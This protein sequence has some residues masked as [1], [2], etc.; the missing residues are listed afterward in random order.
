MTQDP[1]PEQ[2]YQ[3]QDPAEQHQAPP[4]PPPGGQPPYGYG[5]PGGPVPMSPAEEN[6]WSCAAHWTAL[7]GSVIGGLAFLGP[8]LVMLIKGNASPRVR[9]HAVESL[10][11]QLS[12]LI[13]AVISFVLVFVL[14]GIVLLPIVGIAWL[15]LTIIGTVKSAN[16]EYYR[17]PLTIRMVS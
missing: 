15:V 9:A 8:L 2:P 12:I 10:N 14:V 17:Y 4:P 16:G 13:Y 1:Y 6:T 5:A 11:F 3:G 7:L